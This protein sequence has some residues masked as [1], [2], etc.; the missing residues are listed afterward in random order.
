MKIVLDMNIPEVW[1]TFLAEAGHEAIHWSRVGNIRALDS[2]IMAWAHAHQYVVFTH[3]LD[4]GS[5]LFA[6]TA[7]APSVVQLRS[8]HIVPEVVG[9]VV[10]EALSAC[11][12]VLAAGALAT[13]D[14]RRHRVRLL[15]LRNDRLTKGSSGGS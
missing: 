9:D 7:K 12:D 6:T 5:L 15:P 8:E 10:L 4:F 1:E 11:T 13:I 2:E 14:P 3:D